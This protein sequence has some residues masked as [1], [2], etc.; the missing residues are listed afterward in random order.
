MLPRRYKQG[1]NRQYVMQ[2]PPS[3]DEY[4]DEE[5]PVRAIDVYVD[6]MWGWVGVG[7]GVLKPFSGTYSTLQLGHKPFIVIVVFSLFLLIDSAYQPC[8][9]C[10][11]S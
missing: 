6:A 9:L 5:N 2:L 8:L 7:W 4:I 10:Q 3:I 11:S 1:Q